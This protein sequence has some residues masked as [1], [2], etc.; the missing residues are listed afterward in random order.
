MV[1]R[2]QVLLLFGVATVLGP[3]LLAAEAERSLLLVVRVA[4]MVFLYPVL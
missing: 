3:Q 1:V 4:L 2:V